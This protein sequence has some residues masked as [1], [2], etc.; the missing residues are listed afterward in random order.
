MLGGGPNLPAAP[1]I[2]ADAASRPGFSRKFI[3]TCL[4]GSWTATV[5]SISQLKE[6]IIPERTYYAAL[7]PEWDPYFPQQPGDHGTALLPGRFEWTDD[8]IRIYEV[9]VRQPTQPVWKYMG[10]YDC[11]I[12]QVD[13][14]QWS[15]LPQ[16]TR[17][18]WTKGILRSPWGTRFLRAAGHE[19]P[20]INRNEWLHRLLTGGALSLTRLAMQCIGYNDTL[21]ASMLAHATPGEHVALCRAEQSA[22]TKTPALLETNVARSIHDH[23]Q[24][25]SLSP[26][27]GTDNLANITVGQHGL[28]ASPA[29]SSSR[30]SPISMVA[31]QDN[32]G[33]VESEV[34][35]AGSARSQSHRVRKGKK[36]KRPAPLASISLKLTVDRKAM[37]KLKGEDINLEISFA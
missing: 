27:A 2:P 3:S 35:V 33:V 37:K 10:T 25:R 20:K 30:S 17:K 6:Q 15:L 14:E 28:P 22:I 8:T 1:N 23:Q 31:D 32:D 24:K 13:A 34:V 21:Y 26:L 36:S 9:F 4:G 16:G 7:L 11:D 29:P 19:I 18:I 12:I 5:P